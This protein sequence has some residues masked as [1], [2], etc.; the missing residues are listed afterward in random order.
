MPREKLR[1]RNTDRFGF[2]CEID[3]WWRFAEEL[4]GFDL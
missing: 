3:L 4:I 2:E 1:L